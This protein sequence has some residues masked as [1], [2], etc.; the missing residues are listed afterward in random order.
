MMKKAL[1]ERHNELV[2][3]VMPTA[4]RRRW[5][6]AAIRC[7]L[8]QTW[9]HKELII[10]DDGA[11]SVA[12]LVPDDARIRYVREPKS[13]S[14]GAKRNR[15]C[16]LAR[17]DLI[18]HWDDDDW[19]APDRLE[20]QVAALREPGKRLCG[21]EHLLYYD[22]R[23]DCAYAYRYKDSQR[24]WLSMLCYRRALWQVN[25]FP[26]IQMG[27]DTRFL[28]H[29]AQRE[30]VVL[31][32]AGLNVCFIHG[33]NVSPKR[34]SGPHWRIVPV[35]AVRRILG[36]EWR[37]HP[38][39]IDPA[40]QHG[41]SDSGRPTVR[42]M[43]PRAESRSM[44]TQWIVVIPTCNRPKMLSGLLDDLVREQEKHDQNLV[45]RVYD[46]AS[47]L[48]YAEVR[49]RLAAR[50]WQ[51]HRAERNHGRDRHWQWITKA[52]GDLT[53]CAHQAMILFIHDDYRL[54]DRFFTRALTAWQEIKDDRKISLTV[55][56]DRAR[57]Y[58]RC[59]TGVDPEKVGDVW[60]T[61][62]VDGAFIADLHFFQFLNF[63]V[64]PVS[65]NRWRTAPS[66]SSG[67]GRNLSVHLANAGYNLY[68]THK[69][70]AHHQRGPSGLHPHLNAPDAT[71]RRVP[72]RAFPEA[73][74]H[75]PVRQKWIVVIMTYERPLRLLDLL[76]DILREKKKGYHDIEVRVYD[77]A[78]CM[79]YAAPSA[80][81]QLNRWR[82]IRAGRNHG[83]HI[84]W[85]WIDRVYMDLKRVSADTLMVFLQDDVRLCH[86]FFDKARAQW[87]AIADTR[88]TTL[89]LLMDSQREG[90]PCWT[91]FQPVRKGPVWQTQW[92]DQ[93]FLADRRFLET[94]NFRMPPVSAYRWRANPNLSSGVGQTLSMIMHR[95]GRH[96]YCVDESLIAHMGHSSLMNGALRERETM[97]TVRFADGEKA[98]RQLLHARSVIA[99]LASISERRNQLAQVV[100]T[101]LPQ[102]DVLRVYLNR[103]P[104]IPEFL[105]HPKIET[106]HSDR[107]GSLEDVGKFFWNGED[108]GYHLSCDDDLLYPPD[109]VSRML[110]AVERYDKAVV[111]GFHGVLLKPPVTSYY[112]DRSVYHFTQSLEND[113]SV[114]IV[115]TGCA[116]WHSDCLRVSPEDFPHPYMTDILLGR[117]CQERQIPIIAAAHPAGWLKPQPVTDSIYNRY[118]AND[119]AQTAVVNEWQRWRLFDPAA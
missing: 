30:M 8:S 38:G 20:R 50:G 113:R 110:A 77:D 1:Q 43:P 74:R 109:Y 67:V 44:A 61:Q 56:V 24:R 79:D 81:L 108:A 27:S 18:A 65:E 11:D 111:A 33:G 68:R 59:W 97:Q 36:A 57:R 10:L 28:W 116:G 58:S 98:L 9:P 70:L 12:D 105:R 39:A 7:F 93:L 29:V 112:R 80:L 2:S 107:Y 55:S 47:T 99:S 41:P 22:A 17:G 48:D 26:N 78:S 64:P 115:G 100:K 25:P 75:S 84:F 42:A 62:W 106:A 83:K 104:R 40:A 71:C 54:D 102:V 85:Q 119:G 118:A 114:H 51:Y 53:G 14:L 103:Y 37:N 72:A 82:Y 5:V 91:G 63:Q 4:D 21:I 23:K 32:N 49:R 94:V 117:R 101:L 89:T 88:K 52:F 95:A 34:A 90:R 76:N 13:P 16:A 73:N 86:E 46:D 66:L 45:V 15:L 60:R 35:D 96:M 87:H 19:Y 6:P 3:C 31:E 92:V 69:N